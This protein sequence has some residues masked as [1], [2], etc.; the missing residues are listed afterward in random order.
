MKR[1]DTVSVCLMRP[2]FTKCQR[3]SPSAIA[4]PTHEP[5]EP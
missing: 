1:G 2:D 5:V 4:Q 3:S